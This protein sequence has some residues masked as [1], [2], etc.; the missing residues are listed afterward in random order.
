[1]RGQWR[2]PLSRVVGIFLLSAT[3]AQRAAAQAGICTWCPPVLPR[4]APT[5]VLNESTILE[6]CNRTGFLTPA[7]VAGYAVVQLD[8][9]G[10]R[11]GPDG[12]AAARPMDP[13]ERL[14][15]QAALLK[16]AAP[17]QKVGVYKN[18]AWAMAWMT[19][20]REKL[21][22]PALAHWFLRFAATPP[23]ANKSYWQPPCDNTE[24]KPIC[25]QLYHAQTQSPGYPPAPGNDGNCSA[26]GCD[27]GGSVPCGAYLWDYRVP[28][29]RDFVAQEYILGATGAGNENVS[30]VYL[31]D[32][33]SNA[34]DPTDAPD[35]ASSPIG[36]PTE[37][38]VHCI[39]DMSLTQADT[40][41]ITAGFR[42]TM[43]TVQAGL[44]AAGKFSWA[45]FT[46]IYG[47]PTPKG[48]VNWFREAAPPLAGRALMMGFSKSPA[49]ALEDVATFLLVRG[50][51]A[52]L[53]W[54]WLH[55]L[56]PPP[57]PALVHG[58]YGVPAGNL[59]EGPPGVFT[60]AWS[61]AD[62]A[63]DCNAYVATI[64]PR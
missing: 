24:G 1:M 54:G 22:D 49:L 25:S 31:D 19:S 8:W 48:C 14:L 59:T 40:T 46:P 29:V 35:C 18:M 34:T 15:R 47:A 44:I 58:D 23:I 50:P 9:S 63:F 4:W 16:A 64:T 45:F 39:A 12:W 13:E 51:Y 60:R 28:A 61:K 56:Q 41:A 5:Y 37:I 26:P 3:L 11:M 17:R 57:L 33:W 32:H 62:V 20:V 7:D 36:G 38:N 52:Y 27:C 2:G 55:C 21:S 6:P 53:G 30:I 10:A 43:L 42:E